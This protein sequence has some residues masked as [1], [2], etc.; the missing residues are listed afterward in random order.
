MC[1]HSY[2]LCALWNKKR[3]KTQTSPLQAIT[4][5]ILFSACCIL[6][7]L[8]NDLMIL[9]HIALT[10]QFKSF[11]GQNTD[12]VVL[13]NPFCTWSIIWTELVSYFLALVVLFWSKDHVSLCKMLMLSKDY[14]E[15]TDLTLCYGSIPRCISSIPGLKPCKVTGNQSYQINV[16][17]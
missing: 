1:D 4:F 16:E 3:V 11:D 14:A 10:S 12:E 6:F 2:W 13:L 7:F 5:R 15:K 9:H 8:H 17:L